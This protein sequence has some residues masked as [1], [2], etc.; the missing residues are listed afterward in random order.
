MILED[1][2]LLGA[3]CLKRFEGVESVMAAPL[4]PSIFAH[5]QLPYTIRRA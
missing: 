3:A 5:A 4:P 1:K 2:D